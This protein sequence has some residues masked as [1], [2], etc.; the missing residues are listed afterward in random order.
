MA[1]WK[2]LGVP[3]HV[4]TASGYAPIGTR[5]DRAY[6]CPLDAPPLVR[7]GKSVTLWNGFSA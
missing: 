4:G 2:A 3:A 1:Q 7:P 6:R 5:P